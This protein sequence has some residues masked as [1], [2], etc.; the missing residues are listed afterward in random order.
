VPQ[1]LAAWEHATVEGAI[2][3]SVPDAAALLDVMSVPDRLVMYRAPEPDRPYAEEVGR[4]QAPL[5]IGLLL[6]APS[7]VPV[8]PACAEAAVRTGKMLESL[9]HAVFPVTPRFFTPE[10]IMGYA[11]TIVDAALWS[12]PYDRPED[13]EP[14]LRHRMNRAAGKHSGVYTR[15][16][17]QLQLE[18]VAARAH[19]GRD[20]DVLHTPTMASPPPPAVTV[21]A[22]AHGDPDGPRLTENQMISFTA[23]CNITGLPAISLPVH[24]SPAGLPIGS[25][26]IG[27]PWDEAVLVRLASALEQLERWDL[28]RPPRFSS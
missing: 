12:A 25:Q 4:D 11:H 16:A 1:Y 15:A 3:R 7:G 8:D 19:W 17:A 6:D 18:S 13:A 24:T 9:G 14:H 22:E 2:T 20:F 27:G 10:A 21:L 23:L 28:R 26:L 5:R